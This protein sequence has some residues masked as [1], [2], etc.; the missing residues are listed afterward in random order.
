MID[1]LMYGMMPSANTVICD[2]FWP[3]NMSYSPNRLL[4][5]ACVASSCS[6]FPLMPGVG[7]CAPT[8]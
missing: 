7:T 3:E 5:A 2:R 1:A 8:R 6:A 4:W